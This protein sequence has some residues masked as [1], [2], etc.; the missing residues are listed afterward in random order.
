MLWYSLQFLNHSY[1]LLQFQSFLPWFYQKPLL[2]TS[3][4]SGT[5][6]NLYRYT[7]F[8]STQCLTSQKYVNRLLAQ[9]FATNCT[10]VFLYIYKWYNCQ[11]ISVSHF[12]V[13]TT[14]FTTLYRYQV[15]LFC[16]NSNISTERIV[17]ES[18]SILS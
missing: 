6:R 18:V 10:C 3:I 8:R 14:P 9:Y 5:A 17:K 13:L 16:L 11:S 7:G 12:D 2:T 15:S 4:I 1:V